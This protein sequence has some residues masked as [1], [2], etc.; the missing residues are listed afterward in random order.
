M[1]EK[2]STFTEKY[3]KKF[4]WM[5]CIYWFFV[6]CYIPFIFFISSPEQLFYVIVLLFAPQVIICAWEIAIT[7]KEAKEFRALEEKQQQEKRE[8]ERREEMGH[9]K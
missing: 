9:I 1:E 2:D 3:E 7:L 8:Q 6:P 5:F 4:F